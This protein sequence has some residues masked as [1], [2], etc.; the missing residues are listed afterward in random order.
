MKQMQANN[1]D[2]LISRKGKSLSVG[3]ALRVPPLALGKS[4]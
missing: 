3:S 4:I 1:T 2:D